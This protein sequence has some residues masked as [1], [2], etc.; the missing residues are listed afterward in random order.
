MNTKLIVTSITGMI[1]VG[2]ISGLVMGY[3]PGGIPEILSGI[4]S[5]NYDTSAKMSDEVS[6]VVTKSDNSQGKTFAISLVEDTGTT[7]RP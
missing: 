1:V 4:P 2:V 7:D 3:T 5:S 6:A